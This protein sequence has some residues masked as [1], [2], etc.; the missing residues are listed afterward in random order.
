MSEWASD[1]EIKNMSKAE[2]AQIYEKAIRRAKELIGRSEQMITVQLLS[3][4][5]I[6]IHFVER[7]KERFA[8]LMD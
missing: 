3:K 5:K 6:P 2:K 7:G 8:F 1:E 4:D